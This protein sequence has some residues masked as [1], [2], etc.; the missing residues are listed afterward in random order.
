MT[1]I[2]IGKLIVKS[3]VGKITTKSKNTNF[4][5]P[6]PQFPGYHFNPMIFKLTVAGIR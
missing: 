5:W 1:G 6:L 2:Q 3:A 4:I